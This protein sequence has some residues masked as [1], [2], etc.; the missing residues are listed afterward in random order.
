M[1]SEGN[2]ISLSDVFCAGYE[3][4]GGISESEKFC[5]TRLED[6]ILRL[7]RTQLFDMMISRVVLF[8]S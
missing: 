7:I 5:Q 8:R 2:L 6:L 1:V 3:A 4:I